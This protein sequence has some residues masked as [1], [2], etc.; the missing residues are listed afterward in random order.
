MSTLYGGNKCIKA[1]TT[2]PEKKSWW[3]AR[4]YCL[5]DMKSADLASIQTEH[6]NGVIG[7]LAG[8]KDLWVGAH[9]S[10]GMNDWHWVDENDSTYESWAPNMPRPEVTLSNECMYTKPDMKWHDDN[11]AIPRGFVCSKL[12]VLAIIQKSQTPPAP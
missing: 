8:T 3:Q 5:I 4:N 1:F 10:S 9:R 6:L 2:D 7:T 12:S 11:C